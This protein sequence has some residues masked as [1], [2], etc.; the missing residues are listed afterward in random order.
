LIKGLDNFVTLEPESHIYTDKDGGTYLSVSKFLDLFS[1]KFDR[2]GISKMSAAK[3]GV[4]QEEILAEWDKKR[5]DSIDHGNRIHHALERY[6]KS[7]TILP[8]DEDLRPMILSVTKQYSHYYRCYQE[9]CLYDTEFMIAGTSDKV[10]QCTSSPKSIFDLS[11]YKTNLSKGI[12]FKNDYGQYMLGPLSHLQDCNYVK[13]SL[14]LSIYSYL[15][16]KKTGCKIGQ[17]SIHYIPA[18][19]Y[20]YHVKYPVPYMKMEVE[21]M[22]KWKQENAIPLPIIES[23]TNKSLIPEDWSL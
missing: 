18:H 11:D 3:K 13:Y 14:Q 7:T 4:S 2:M 12:Q 19:N 1:K 10:L 23:P 6:E 9:V 16:Q 22:L 20:L 21:A 8:E 15:L 5:D 17:L